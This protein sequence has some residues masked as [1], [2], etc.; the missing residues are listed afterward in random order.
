MIM[1]SIN[2]LA[3]LKVSVR[4]M[5]LNLTKLNSTLLYTCVMCV[6]KERLESMVMTSYLNCG[7]ILLFL[8]EIVIFGI[9]LQ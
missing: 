2:N 6:L 8:P 1:A 9:M 5:Y 7:T 3:A 4:L